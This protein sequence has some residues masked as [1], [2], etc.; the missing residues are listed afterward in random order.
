M[1]LHE[2][3]FDVYVIFIIMFCLVAESTLEILETEWEVL[4][5]LVFFFLFVFAGQE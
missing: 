5:V 4:E 1:E 2:L 3:G